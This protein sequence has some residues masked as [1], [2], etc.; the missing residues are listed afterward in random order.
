MKAISRLI[1]AAGLS[2]GALAARAQTPAQIQGLIA[3]G[4]D[5][6]AVSQLQSVLAAH[7]QSGTAWYL[8]AEARDAL[9][10][11][12]AARDAL[13]K[14]EQVSPGLPFADP[15]KVAALQA[16]LNHGGG[17]PVLMV[18]G[19]LFVLFVLLR[20]FARR[21][22]VP[23]GYGPGYGETMPPAPAYGGGGLGSSL[24]SG[25]AAGAGFAVGE[26]IVED[27]SGGG[28][29]FGQ[30]TTPSWDD[31]LNGSPGW[32]DSSGTDNSGW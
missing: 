14:A 28:Q 29:A 16:H 4:Q 23:Y 13:A 19:V 11:E 2:L 10:Q 3:D 21:R 31:G 1:V 22:A 27:L 24:M 26:R 12:G 20:M 5:N 15:E 6:L 8:M 30:D 25:L 7:P 18:V 32:D 17:H 9:G